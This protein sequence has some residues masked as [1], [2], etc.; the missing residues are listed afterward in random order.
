MNSNIYNINW[1]RL[2]IWLLPI[3]LRT[4][5]MVAW[6]QVLLQPLKESWQSFT[7]FRINIEYKVRHTSQVCYL[8]GAL[9]DSFDNTLRRIVIK[10][11]L[12]LAPVYIYTPLEDKPVW[13][14]PE[15]DNKPVWLYSPEDLTNNDTD[16]I[17]CVPIELKPSNTVA[18]NAY[19]SRMKSLLN[20]YK[21]A[22]KTYRIEWIT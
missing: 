4:T 7:L 15:A 3:A 16:F 20:Y 11:G 17:V 6:L 13:L 21:L 19:I 2:S 5:K 9:N 14:Y 18:L 22:S 8:Q 1:R 12:F 10:N